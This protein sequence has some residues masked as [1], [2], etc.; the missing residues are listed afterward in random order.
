M[1]V[2][3]DSRMQEYEV[4]ALSDGN[5]L[6]ILFRKSGRGEE[7]VNPRFLEGS[8]S[9]TGHRSEGRVE[10]RGASSMSAMR[11]NEPGIP[12]YSRSIAPNIPQPHPLQYQQFGV[13]GRQE[14]DARYEGD[15]F[16]HRTQ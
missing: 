3:V 8:G 5:R 4:P 12:V 15:T 16:D 9:G 6:P 2:G 1:G 11:Y 7:L 13:P 14:E 10:S